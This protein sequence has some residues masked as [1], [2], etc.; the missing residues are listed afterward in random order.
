MA[1]IEA[2]GLSKSFDKK[3]VISGIS[4]S[5]ER[6]EIFGFLGQNG[7][8]KTTTIRILLGLLAPTQGS[9]RVLGSDLMHDDR[10][11][12]RVGVLLAHNG[13]YPRLTAR[14]NLVYYGRLYGCRDADRRAEEL[15]FLVGL[16]DAADV[17]AGDL[18]TGMQRKIGIARAIFHNPEILFLDEPSSGLDP[19]AQHMVR[20]LILNL[21][22]E[23]TITIFLSSHHLDEVQRVCTHVAILHSGKILVHDSVAHLTAGSGRTMY[24]VGLTDPG[25]GEKA[26][27]ILTGLSG[28]GE[29]SVELNRIAMV[30]SGVAP[31]EVVGAL[32]AGGVRVDEARHRAHSL[33]EIYLTVLQEAEAAV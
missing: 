33:E 21:A 28:V 7:A 8:G 17:A 13:L 23:Q 12:G 32:V 4:L 24:E 20:A 3:V 22:R 16:T 1:V 18:S 31:H 10:V 26:S 14:E 27:E 30:L 29:V 2:S 25:E 5:V 15:L 11:R 19:E 9:A 6:G